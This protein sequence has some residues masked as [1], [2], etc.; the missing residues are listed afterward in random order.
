MCKANLFVSVFPVQRQ[1]IR[2]TAEN[3]QPDGIDS[4]FTEFIF[5]MGKYFPC[6]TFVLLFWIHAQPVNDPV[7]TL[8]VFPCTVSVL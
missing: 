8:R 7:V 2:I 1:C 3:I 5:N 4:V 6:K